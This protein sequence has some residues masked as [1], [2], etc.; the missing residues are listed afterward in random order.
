[1]EPIGQ[2]EGRTISGGTSS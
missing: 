2:E 1:M